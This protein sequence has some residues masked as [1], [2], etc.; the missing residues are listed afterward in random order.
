LGQTFKR[1]L[2]IH[3]TFYGED[4]ARL[5]ELQ[6][7]FKKLHDLKNMVN[8]PD[9]QGYNYVSQLDL[10]IE[11]EIDELLKELRQ[12]AVF[13]LTAEQVLVA[14]NEST[15]SEYTTEEALGRLF[16]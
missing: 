3:I 15:Q 9:E 13:E 12:M 4:E 14:L 8:E 10:D 2:E 1:T 16:G 11:R 5:T 6:R 7:Q